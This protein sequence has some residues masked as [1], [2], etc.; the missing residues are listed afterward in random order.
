MFS[1]V[2]IKH[3]S[4]WDNGKIPNVSNKEIIGL[5]KAKRHSQRMPYC[6]SKVFINSFVSIMLLRKEISRFNQK[7]LVL[8]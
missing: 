8:K 6:P 2:S 3:A 1:K 7:I 5:D 4:A